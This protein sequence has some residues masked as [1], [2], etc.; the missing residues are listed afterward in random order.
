MPGTDIRAGKSTA[1][2]A[3]ESVKTPVETALAEGHA[4]IDAIAARTS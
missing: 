3:M 1:K 2:T 4:T